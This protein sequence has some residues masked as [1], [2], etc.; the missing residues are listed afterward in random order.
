MPTSTSNSYSALT[1]DQN[2]RVQAL[3][4]A[5]DILAK[6]I[7]AGAF[8]SPGV[9]PPKVSDLHLLAQYIL[10][11][12]DPWTEYAVGGQ[13]PLP[14]D[15]DHLA[16]LREQ[17]TG[18]RGVPCPSCKKPVGVSSA[19]FDGKVWLCTSNE[20]T[21]CP[22]CRVQV[23]TL[24][25]HYDCGADD[26]TCRELAVAERIV[27]VSGDTL[28]NDGEGEPE[29]GDLFDAPPPG[30]DVFPPEQAETGEV[31]EPSVAWHEN[32]HG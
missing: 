11:G 19:H 13:L 30:G 29:K 14:F 9:E 18:E 32:Q 25:Q 7:S 28:H 23:D 22:V 1:P 26:W 2:A 15:D 17:L 3:T 8:S 16:D 20:P 12:Q 27:E 24:A 21:R 31:D 10:N 4:A 5:R 6:R